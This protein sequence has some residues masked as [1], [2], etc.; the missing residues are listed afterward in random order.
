[1]AMEVACFDLEGVFVPEIWIAVAERTGVDDLRL[2]TRDVADYDTLMRHRLS[3]LDREGLRLADIQSV[4]ATLSPLPGAREFLGWARRNFQ[5]V[6]LSDTF[7]DFAAPLMAQ[8]DQPV[9]FC[10]NLEIDEDGRIAGYRLRL[11]NQKFHAVKAFQDLQFSVL[12]AGDSYNDTAMLCQA[13]AGFLINPP[14]VV[15]EEFPQ[16]PVARSFDEL[17]EFMVAAS[18]RTLVD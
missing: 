9:L 10:H 13:D 3:V 7:Y 11:P 5:V 4:I 8:L 16:L 18:S 1:M 2:T 6:V 17:R 12:A 15:V 14:P